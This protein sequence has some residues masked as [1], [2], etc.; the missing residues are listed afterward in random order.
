MS[1]RCTTPP[2]RL[3]FP[4]LITP[5]KN[6][7]TGQNQYKATLLFRRDDPGVKELMRV[8]LKVAKD[9]WGEKIPKGVAKR[10]LAKQSGW[11][12]RDQGDFDEYKGFEPGALMLSVA[13]TT[14]PGFV[15]RNR[16]TL[17]DPAS[18]IYPGCWVRVTLAC[19]TY[20]TDGNKGVTFYLNNVQ[21]LKDGPRLDNRIDAEDENWGDD[22][23]DD[24]F[25]ED[26]DKPA[27]RDPLD[28]D[29]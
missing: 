26:D 22:I 14:P 13:S 25:D 6:E 19:A 29:D 28:D 11:P 3:A 10:D 17:V 27:R 20:D 1:E 18:E 12:F 16:E 7:R 2:C 9:K 5:E 15:D 4:K 21:K 24:F 23:D 8:A